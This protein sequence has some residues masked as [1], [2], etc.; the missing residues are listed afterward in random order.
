MKLN[1]RKALVQA[2]VLADDF[3]EVEAQEY[4][5]KHKDKVWYEDFMLLFNILRDD[6]FEIDM[7]TYLSIAGALAYV[8]MPVDV[9]PDFIPGVG[10][11]DDIFVVGIVISNLS[12]EIQRY[13]Q[14]LLN[15]KIVA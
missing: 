11:I 14:H 1:K 8:I 13:K 2:E 10:F 7:K 5:S 3:N 12:D 9:I 6:T 4:I 15:S